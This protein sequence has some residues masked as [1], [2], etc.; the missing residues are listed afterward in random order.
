MKTWLIPSVAIVAL[1]LNS[2]I[3]AA[4]VESGLEVGEAPGAFNVKDCTGPN[5]GKSLCY[6]CNYG[7]R[8]VVSVFT[9]S[10]DDN[11]ASL[12]QQIDKQVGENSGKQMAS[13]VVL[14]TDDP[15]GAEAQLK[16]FAEKNKIKNVPLTIFD[17][18]AGPE[19]YKIS[20]DAEV[21]VNM[22]VKSSTK[23]NHAFAKGQLNKEAVSTV[24]SDTSKILN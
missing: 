5:A 15:D 11:L 19:G 2:L 8:P 1:A 4:E 3:M 20:K 18:V 13:F 12:V 21:T 17:G 23:S 9:R 24:V 14:L 7:G 16:A 22:W 6:R 10:L